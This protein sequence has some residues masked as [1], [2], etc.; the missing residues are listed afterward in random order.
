MS[1]MTAKK[2]KDGLLSGI[3][4]GAAFLIF[5]LLFDVGFFL[6]LVIG[7]AAFATGFFLLFRVKPE[8]VLEAEN[9]IKTALDQGTA[10]LSQIMKLRSQIKKPPV[11]AKIL[12][13]ENMI[14]KIITQV[15]KEPNKLNKAQQF[16]NYYL[17]STINILKKYVELSAQ[18][19]GDPSIKASLAK[20]ESMLQTIR[21]AFEKQLANLLSDDVLDLDTELKVLDQ[22]IKSEGL[23]KE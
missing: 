20:V 15:G 14:T 18:N 1:D 3:L 16:L 23:G 2:E 8:E 17:D 21:D 9:T 12:E 11:T 7:A 19:L 10:K 13:I 22:T 6:S 4:G 5:L